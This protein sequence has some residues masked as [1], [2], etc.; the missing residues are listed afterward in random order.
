MT[1]NEQ[2]NDE[3][4]DVVQLLSTDSSDFTVAPSLLSE[5]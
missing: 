1:N 3:L 5:S 4:I 2:L